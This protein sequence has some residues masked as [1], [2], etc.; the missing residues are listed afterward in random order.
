M[1]WWLVLYG[2]G[3]QV[4]ISGTLYFLLMSMRNSDIVTGLGA[5]LELMPL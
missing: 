4:A 3:L 5:A 1:A 2:L